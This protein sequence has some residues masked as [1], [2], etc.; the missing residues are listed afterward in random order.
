[1]TI[2]EAGKDLLLAV[3]TDETLWL[4]ELIFP[5][6]EPA[7]VRWNPLNGPPD[8]EY[9]NKVKPFWDRMEEQYAIKD[10]D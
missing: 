4:G 2:A 8:G 7:V 3:C 9:W 1:M 5:E 6:N 10:D